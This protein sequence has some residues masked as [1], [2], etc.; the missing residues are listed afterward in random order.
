[1]WLKWNNLP[2]VK[3]N[4]ANDLDLGGCQQPLVRLGLLV[5]LKIKLEFFFNKLINNYIYI[6]IYSLV[7]KIVI[8]FSS[9]KICH[10][11][12]PYRW[13]T[14]TKKWSPLVLLLLANTLWNALLALNH[15][16]SLK[17]GMYLD[18][19]PV[20][21]LVW[22]KVITLIYNYGSSTWIALA[23]IKNISYYFPNF[24]KIV[25]LYIYIVLKILERSGKKNWDF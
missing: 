20:E 24:W 8:Q 4:S 16:K 22:A 14:M 23:L 18:I 9:E 17:I 3:T 6:Y 12:G 7:K 15:S 2:I 25:N 1:L 5:V 19:F 21:K 10:I 13:G 11:V